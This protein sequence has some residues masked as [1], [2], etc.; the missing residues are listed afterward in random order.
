M[1]Y[2]W[3]R[4][5]ATNKSNTVIGL[6]RNRPV[7]Q[8]LLE[9]EGLQQ[10]KLLY[11]DMADHISLNTAAAEVSKITGG[12]LDYLIINGAYTDEET[13]SLKPTE[14]IGREDF[15]KKDM[16]TSLEV[17]VLGA[18]Y[19]INAFIGLVKNGAV[20]KVIVTSSGLGDPD[21]GS[22]GDVAQS[23]TYSTMKAALN[24]V[25]AKFAAELRS[26]KVSFLAISPG[27][28]A[29]KESL[30]RDYSPS[31]GSNSGLIDS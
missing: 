14:F 15:L 7:V 19:S 12:T 24:M 21:L 5:L 1:Q 13:S 17:N 20:K 25:T 2:Q 3:L 30:D 27:V 16:I 8:K 31:L 9:A 10:V 29:T 6:V 22:T 11:G 23:L 4:E 18:I 28:V 26:E